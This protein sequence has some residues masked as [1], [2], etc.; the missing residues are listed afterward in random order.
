M[1]QRARRIRVLRGA[2]SILPSPRK[3]AGFSGGC[4]ISTSRNTGPME[5]WSTTQS[6]RRATSRPRK[7]G[8]KSMNKE[9]RLRQALGIALKNLVYVANDDPPSLWAHD[10]V[11][12]VV[13][14]AGEHEDTILSWV[15]NPAPMQSSAPLDL[16]LKEELIHGG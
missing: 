16:R 8:R 12:Q 6:G 4:V 15:N 11:D 2:L 13:E 9:I 3:G 5:H 7:N 14:A 10:V 1:T